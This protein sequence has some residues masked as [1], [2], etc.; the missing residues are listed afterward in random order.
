M[1]QQSTSNAVDTEL[2]AAAALADATTNPTTT[3]VGGCLHA[4]NGAT[5][6][7]VRVANIRKD[8]ATVTI[9]TITTVWTPTSGKKFR[10]M[11]GMISVSAAGSVLFE[12]NAAGTTV[13]RTPVLLAATP[14]NFDLQNGILSAAANN[15][16]KATLSVAGSITGT[17]WGVEET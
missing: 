5:W 10:I 13:F 4:F 14:Y 16:L 2:A 11:G 1:S 7:R 8:L 17:I 6:D 9:T 12:D 3:L 15:V